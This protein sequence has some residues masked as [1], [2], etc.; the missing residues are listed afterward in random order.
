[1]GILFRNSRVT[2]V[3]MRRLS[4]PAQGQAIANW[5]LLAGLLGSTAVKS[6]RVPWRGSVWVVR[7][8]L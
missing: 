6:G 7:V 1:M 3:K 8:V 5:A 2:T 4:M